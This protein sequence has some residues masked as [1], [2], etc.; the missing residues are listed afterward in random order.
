M[1]QTL[2]KHYASPDTRQSDRQKEKNIT[3]GLN[4]TWDLKA[5]TYARKAN[6]QNVNPYDS[7]NFAFIVTIHVPDSQNLLVP[8]NILV[9]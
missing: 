5:A 3:N 7:C 6:S 1:I 2:D 4:I 8:A 9:V